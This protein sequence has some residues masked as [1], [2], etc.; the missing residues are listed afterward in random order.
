MTAHLLPLFS[1]L[2]IVTAMLP[3]SNSSLCSTPQNQ[4]LLP[5]TAKC[6][7]APSISVSDHP[8]PSILTALAKR[9]FLVPQQAG[10]IQQAT[11]TKS[12]N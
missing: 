7:L 2:P 10:L 11:L 4:T 5:I 6:S 8:S 1:P 12:A 3:L 9:A